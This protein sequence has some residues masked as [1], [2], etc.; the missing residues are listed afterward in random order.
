MATRKKRIDAFSHEGVPP[1]DCPLKSFA[2]IMLA[3]MSFHSCA[4]GATAFGITLILAIA[5][6]QRSLAG[7]RADM[8]RTASRILEGLVEWRGFVEGRMGIGCW[9]RRG[10]GVGFSNDQIK[11]RASFR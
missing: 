6:K 2:R 10:R 5:S 1:A 3:R 11:L 7:A 9:L 8:V 4:D